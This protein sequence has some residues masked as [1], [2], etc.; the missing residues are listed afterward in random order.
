MWKHQRWSV[1]TIDLAHAYKQLG[2][3]PSSRWTSVGAIFNP[4]RG[5]ADFFVQITLP[6]GAAAAVDGFNRAGRSLWYAGVLH[7]GLLWG[8]YVDDFPTSTSNALK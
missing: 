4:K 8:N 6:F 5:K 2:V 7:F 3:K 1:K